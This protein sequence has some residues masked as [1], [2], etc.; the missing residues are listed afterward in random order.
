[1]F[2]S[3]AIFTDD[4]TGEN[5]QS[6]NRKKAVAGKQTGKGRVGGGVHKTSEQT[7]HRNALRKGGERGSETESTRTGWTKKI[8]SSRMK[9]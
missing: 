4:T 3:C 1:M 2:I 6:R 8:S 7:V 9:K 5:D